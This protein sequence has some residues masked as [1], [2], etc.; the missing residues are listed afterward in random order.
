MEDEVLV[1]TGPIYTVRLEILNS[2]VS[3]RIMQS[4][5]QVGFP[6]R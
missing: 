1:A 6:F 4:T 3:S 5:Y 2:A